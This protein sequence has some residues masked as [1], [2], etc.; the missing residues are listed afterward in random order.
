MIWD[1][2]TPCIFNST[3]EDDLIDIMDAVG[4]FI[5]WH[6]LGLRLGLKDNTLDVIVEEKGKNVSSCIRAMFRAWLRWQDNVQDQQYGL[7]SWRR[8]IKAI[9]KLDKNLATKIQTSAPWQ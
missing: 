6:D 2:K 1:I 8:L 4:D 9:A 3:G 7:P 5:K